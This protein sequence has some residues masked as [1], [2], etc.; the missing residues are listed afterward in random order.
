MRNMGKH[1]PMFATRVG[2]L[3]CSLL[4]ALNTSAMAASLADGIAVATP[5]IV[6]VLVKQKAPAE[7]AMN[8]APQDNTPE[9][10][11]SKMTNGMVSGS[12]IIISPDGYI[13]S[14][15]H[16][17]DDADAILVWTSDKRKFEAKLMGRDRRLDL[18][19]LKIEASGLSAAK[20][21]DPMS[22]RL[23]EQIFSAG[24]LSEGFGFEPVVSN[25]IISTL[26][27]ISNHG[28]YL[29]MIQTTSQLTPSMGGGGLFNE[30][31]ELLGL[32]AQ[33][34]VNKK[35]GQS[36][37]FSL[38][39]ND[40]MAALPELKR[41]GRIRRSAIGVKIGEVSDQVATALA[42]PSVSGALV[43]ALESNGPAEKADIRPGDVI[44]EVAQ[45][46]IKRYVEFF[47]VIGALEPGTTVPVK[48]WRRGQLIEILVT[49][50][51]LQ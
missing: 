8:R 37:S 1:L 18:A 30:K 3:F 25:G 36:L 50:R 12:G 24:M 28:D 21:G 11:I 15:S 49:T 9:R 10:P 47:R 34:Y 29:P 48:L 46:P 45:N 7:G 31:G 14:V 39:I 22:V 23:G 17:F 40:A 38:P 26:N 2:T 6:H 20:I 41:F 44:V 32:S 13:Y 51:E 35:M 16:L 33:I 4:F 27:H 43:Q 42:L 19:L 5:S